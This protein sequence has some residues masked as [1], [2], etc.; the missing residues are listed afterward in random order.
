MPRV[1]VVIA[2]YNA[3]GPLRI[4]LE[5]LCRSRFK[6]FEVCICDDGSRDDT[7]RV[8]H[9]YATRLD[10]RLAVNENNRG[11]TDARNRAL[12]MARAPLLLFLDADVRLREGTIGRLLECMERT[13]A[14][15]VEGATSGVSL[16]P[17]PF[18]AYYALLV[19]HSSV[20]AGPVLRH[21][22][23]NSW[24]ALCRRQVLEA[25][26]GYE[27]LPKGVDIENESLGRR[28]AAKGFVIHLDPGIRVDHHWGGCLK[29]LYIFTNRVY[30][31]VKFFLDVDRSFGVALTTGSYALGTAALPGAVLVLALL[32]PRPI[33]GALAGAAAAVFLWAYAPFYSFI[34]RRRGVLFLLWSVLLSASFA[35]LV[36]VSAV[37]SAAEELLRWAWRGRRTLRPE[38]GPPETVPPLKTLAREPS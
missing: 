27:V 10:L 31:W 32:G 13:G 22:V 17:G 37:Y 21:D 2:A 30:W 3:A 5:S 15:V 12:A 7:R 18:S 23:F 28:I 16:N 26:G 19:H 24:C 36:F 38:P 6:D 33:A 34:L 4:L 25:V 35:F 29:L 11:A 8:V 1:C 14:D 9:Y 20:S